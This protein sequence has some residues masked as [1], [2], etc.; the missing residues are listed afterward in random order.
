MAD[1]WKENVIEDLEMGILEFETMKKFLEVISKKF[2]G[3]NEESK[4]KEIEQG[5]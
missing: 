3:G 1:V 5:Q 4:L 2:K